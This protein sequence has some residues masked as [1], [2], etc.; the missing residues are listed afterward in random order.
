MTR[1]ATPFFLT[2]LLCLAV[3]GADAAEKLIADYGG[4]AG[5]QSATWVGRDLRIFEKHGLDVVSE[6]L[7]YAML[8]KISVSDNGPVG[9]ESPFGGE[10]IPLLAAI[11]R[12]SAIWGMH[13]QDWKKQRHPTTSFLTPSSPNPRSA[14]P[15]IFAARE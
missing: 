3:P 9:E 5:F 8:G 6:E 2:A 7:R 13:G 14:V 15:K 12:K 11:Y 4:H 1:F 10:P